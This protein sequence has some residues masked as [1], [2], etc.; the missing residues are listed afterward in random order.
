MLGLP[1]KES[2]LFSSKLEA[3]NKTKSNQKTPSPDKSLRIRCQSCLCK[4]GSLAGKGPTRAI[5]G[6]GRSGRRPTAGACQ[7]R[8]L[9]RVMPHWAAPWGC[10]RGGG[11]GGTSHQ[12][13]PASPFPRPG[14]PPDIRTALPSAPSPAPLIKTGTVA[15]RS[16]RRKRVQASKSSASTGTL[17]TPFDGAPLRTPCL[18][19]ASETLNP[20]SVGQDWLVAGRRTPGGRAGSQALQY[21]LSAAR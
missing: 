18:Q 9:G 6:S 14:P 7:R 5:Q 1:G 13:S 21:R 2:G 8:G 4:L 17:F 3:K 12:A 15:P 10:A 20:E 19:E 11:A 16:P